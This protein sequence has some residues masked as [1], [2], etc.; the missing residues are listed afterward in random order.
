MKNVRVCYPSGSISLNEPKP[1]DAEIIWLGSDS[2]AASQI[3]TF[4]N[5]ESSTLTTIKVEDANHVCVLCRSPKVD[6]LRLGPLYFGEDLTAHYFCLLFAA[7]LVQKGD[8]SEGILG[9]LP[10]DI[11]Q[12]A[13]RAF[14]LKCVFCR[15]IGAAS[16]C[17]EKKCKTSFHFRCGLDNGIAYHFMGNY[18]CYCVNH[19]KFTPAKEPPPDQECPVCLC[20]ISK[21]ESSVSASCCKSAVF[22]KECIQQMAF[23]AGYFFKCPTCNA[24]PNFQEEMRKQGVFVPEQDAS[25]ELEPNAFQELLFTYSTC[26]AETCECPRGRNY[27]ARKGGWVLAP[28]QRLWSSGTHRHCGNLKTMDGWTCASCLEVGARAEQNKSV[29]KTVPEAPPPPEVNQPSTSAAARLRNV[30]ASAFQS[31]SSSSS[32]EETHD[33]PDDLNLNLA[34]IHISPECQDYFPFGR[35]EIKKMAQKGNILMDWKNRDLAVSL[36]DVFDLRMPPPPEPNPAPPRQRPF[37]P[38]GTCTS[39]GRRLKRFRIR[40]L[41]SRGVVKKYKSA[42]R[43]QPRPEKPK[44]KVKVV[45]ENQ[46]ECLTP[47]AAQVEGELLEPRVLRS[48]NIDLKVPLTM[49]LRNLSTVNF[50]IV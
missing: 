32:P 48:V 50:L 43:V 4:S 25:W 45:R 39:Q 17:C 38:A 5:V 23:S 13:K 46:Q 36:V 7:G 42:A 8:D 21:G 27:G 28:V 19:A 35:A 1:C 18:E 41:W 20:T 29:V 40:T 6:E 26:D 11:K 37:K 2:R 31:E 9:F 49:P 44:R 12:E 30:L 34:L 15:S 33:T 16:G 14:R 22:H 3:H 24:Q 10:V 47:P